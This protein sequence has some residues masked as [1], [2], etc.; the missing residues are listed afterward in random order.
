MAV[1]GCGEPPG[2]TKDTANKQCLQCNTK[3][4]AAKRVQ[5]VSSDLF[6][7]IFVKV[8]GSTDGI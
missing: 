2:L 8:S 1:A 3:K 4:Q 7:A 6:F 5:D